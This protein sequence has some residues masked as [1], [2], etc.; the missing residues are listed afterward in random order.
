MDLLDRYLQAVKKHLPWKGQDD[1][2]AELRANLESQLEDKEAGL[3]RPMTTAE[4]EAW[5]KQLG[6]PMQVAARYQPQRYLIGPAVFPIYW[7][8]LRLALT[9][10][11]IIYSIVVAAQFF[12][13]QNPGNGAPLEAVLRMPGILITTAVW[14]TLIFAVVEFASTYFPEK[15]KGL[16]APSADWSPA[17]L[18]AVEKVVANGKK[19]RS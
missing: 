18:P 1:I 15:F 17:A 4:G 8:V 19:H 9:W 12:A 7:Y 13:E 16:P 6:S 14:V 3:G 11:L 5:L 10:A 2:V